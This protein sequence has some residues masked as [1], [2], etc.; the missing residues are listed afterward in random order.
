MSEAES[1][2]EGVFFSS[3]V[4]SRS[5]RKN[6]TLPLFFHHPRFPFFLL[7]ST[8]AIMVRLLACCCSLF[9]ILA[10]AL[11]RGQSSEAWRRKKRQQKELLSLPIAA[12][13]VGRLNAQQSPCAFALSHPFSIH[14]RSRRPLRWKPERELRHAH[15]LR[16]KISP[17]S[18][19]RAPRVWRRRR[20]RRPLFFLRAINSSTLSFL[21]SLSHALLFFSQDGP[22]KLAIVMKVIGRTGS[23]GQVRR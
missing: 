22:I 3:E 23:R 20:R 6:S 14:L 4:P 13:A 12:A 9:R 10:S 11:K 7:S 18:V 21:L 16:I 5:L 15:R 1:P 8:K 19:A 17:A 2:R